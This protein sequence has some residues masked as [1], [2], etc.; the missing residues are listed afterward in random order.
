MRGV[1]SD[2]ALLRR[3]STTEDMSNEART[4]SLKTGNQDMMKGGR[5]SLI[6]K[7]KYKPI[8]K[9]STPETAFDNGFAAPA[10]SANGYLGLLKSYELML[11]SIGNFVPP[12]YQF[13]ERNSL[14]PPMSS[15]SMLNNLHSTINMHGRS[16]LNQIAMWEN[17]GLGALNNCSAR[18]FGPSTKANDHLLL[19]LA[20]YLLLF[21]FGVMK[22]LSF[23]RF[24]RYNI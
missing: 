24:L 9:L 2:L 3:S 1:S 17:S 14:C 18:N 7:L 19:T 21:S 10:S 12:D 22:Q 15:L 23:D 16:T 4:R 5:A 13:G 11:P 8:S 20:G 6:V